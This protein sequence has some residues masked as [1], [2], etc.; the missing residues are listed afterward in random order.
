M[1]FC[2][3]CVWGSTPKTSGART[4]LR[5]ALVCTTE[6]RFIPYRWAKEPDVVAVYYGADWCA[7]CHE[8]VPKLKAVYEEL[9]RHGANT[10][11]VFVSLDYSKRAMLR[12]MQQQQ[13]PWPAVDYRRLP[14][15]PALR[16]LAGEGP[17]NLVL[18]DREGRILASAWQEKIYLGTSAVLRSWIALTRPEPVE[19]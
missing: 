4:E 7:P 15:L 11:V 10:E 19:N 17:P 16:R 9:R 12:Y 14:S 1:L 18:I 6:S 5:R 2:S 8:F 3:V 13:M